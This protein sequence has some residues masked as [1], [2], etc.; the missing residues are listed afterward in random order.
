MP[1]V[2]PSRESG[3]GSELNSM[4]IME[5]RSGAVVPTLLLAMSLCLSGVAMAQQ[6]QL[7]VEELEKYISEQKELLEE[8]RAN[9]DETAEKAE[10]VRDALAEQEAHKALVEEELNTLC[11]EQEELKPGSYEEC[12][13]QHSN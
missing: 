5:G 13:S 2:V 9:R 1:C 7:S 10:Q 11:Q 8:V 3:T 4:K 6:K 12:R